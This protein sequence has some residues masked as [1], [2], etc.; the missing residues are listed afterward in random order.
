MTKRYKVSIVGGSEPTTASGSLSYTLIAT[1]GNAGTGYSFY[2][3]ATATAGG[4]IPNGTWTQTTTDSESIN[5]SAGTTTTS[6]QGNTTASCSLIQVYSGAADSSNSF[7]PA[8]SGSQQLSA[9]YTDSYNYVAAAGAAATVESS[10]SVTTLYSASGG[11]SS[12]GSGTTSGGQS[13][14]VGYSGAGNY[15]SYSGD[16]SPNEWGAM[17]GGSIEGSFSQS[18]S[19]TVSLSYSTNAS[20]TPA[21]S[22]APGYWSTTSGTGETSNSGGSSFSYSGSGSYG[23]G[24][25]GPSGT[26]S[27]SGWANEG[28]LLTPELSYPTR[29]PPFLTKVNDELLE[30]IQVNPGLHLTGPFSQTPLFMDEITAG[31]YAGRFSVSEFRGGPFLNLA[32]PMCKKL[33]GT[34]WHLGRGNLKLPREFWDEFITRPF[35]PTSM[36]REAY[37]LLVKRIKSVLHRRKVGA[38]T[39]WIGK[40]A[41]SLLQKGNAII[42]CRGDWLSVDGSVIK[43]NLAP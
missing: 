26:M 36:S 16:T 34:Y 6:G 27:Q 2:M 24:G 28:I 17:H 14:L 43:S 15:T 39:V 22:T 11:G 19:N 18:Q 12:G 3:T 38:F 37:S 13:T 4:D 23:G 5:L 7:C 31:K 32:V 21:T 41:F 25:C 42:L 30:A 10:G 8:I 20:Y 29:K 1:G 33:D 35:S 40:S 9:T